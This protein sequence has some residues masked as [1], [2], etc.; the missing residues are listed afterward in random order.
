M[1]RRTGYSVLAENLSR[2][3]LGSTLFLILLYTLAQMA[4]CM[5]WFV[6]LRDKNHPIGFWRTFLAYAAGDALN[7]TVP[8]GNL[9]G[10]PV[11]M[12]LVKDVI[13]TEDA[14]A[15]VTVYKYADFLS[16]TLFLGLGW[17][18]HFGFYKM[19]AFWNLGAAVIL[20]VM[21]AAS[22]LF[23]WIQS[24]GLFLPLGKLLNKLGL[25]KWVGNKLQAAHIVD[26]S[27]RQYYLHHRRG[28]ALSVFF[29][30][31]AWFGGVLEIMVFMRFAGLPFS[32]PAAL[33]IE[34]FSLFVNNISFFVPARIGVGEGSR[35]LL[36]V[37]LGYSK[38]AGL[39]YGILRRIR[40]LAWVGI[41][42]LVLSLARR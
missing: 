26:E 2:F 38:A 9:A 32:F 4:F 13:G 12:M 39:T 42:F 25:E 10:E 35:A 24:K 31:M 27:V 8:S 29:N 30:F 20:F 6:L 37:T 23:F 18:L 11:K 28:F 15:S 34:T 3:G 40:E 5:A 7:M 19:P 21:A 36:F 16:M 22:I 1:V 14:L 33:T 41:G 17:L